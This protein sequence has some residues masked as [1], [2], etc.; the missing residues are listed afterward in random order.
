MSLTYLKPIKYVSWK[1]QSNVAVLPSHSTPIYNGDPQLANFYGIPFK[2]HPLHGYRYDR[3]ETNRVTSAKHKYMID[4]INSPGGYITK[5]P[6]AASELLNCADGVACAGNVMQDYFLVPN[7]RTEVPDAPGVERDYCTAADKARRRCRSAVTVLKPT[8]YNRMTEYLQNR[9]KLYQNKQYNF[10][11]DTEGADPTVTPG[12]TP[13]AANNTY[14]A[15]C[16]STRQDGCRTVIYKPSNPSFANQ[17]AVSASGRTAKLK[18]DVVTANASSFASAF[19]KATCSAYRYSGE[20]ANTPYTLKTITE[21]GGCARS[22]YQYRGG[23]NT[24]VMR[25]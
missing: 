6:S 16:A 8:Y 4:K 20:V 9:C 2:A 1:A 25:C 17:G 12:N 19:G 23:M 13:A 11:A 24:R 10:L 5:P 22:R 14:L 3:N 18:Y 7:S 15:N 21:N